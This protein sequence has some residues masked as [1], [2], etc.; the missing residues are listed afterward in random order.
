MPVE[1]VERDLF[2]GFHILTAD[3][4][5]HNNH[6]VQQVAGPALQDNHHWYESMLRPPLYLAYND[7][8]F[9]ADES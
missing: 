6:E 8:N 9:P 1:C 5:A 7:D 4:P 3:R 2:G